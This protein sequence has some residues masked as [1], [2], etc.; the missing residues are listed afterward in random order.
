VVIEEAD[1]EEEEEEEPAAPAEAAPAA[2]E[3]ADVSPPAAAREK[4]EPAV[5]VDE[6]PDT[7][8]RVSFVVRGFSFERFSSAQPAMLEKAVSDEAHAVVAPYIG[9]DANLRIY[10]ADGSAT[11]DDDEAFLD[12]L[13]IV[14]DADINAG[15]SD[16]LIA[17]WERCLRDP[18]SFAG[19]RAFIQVPAA[20]PMVAEGD[21]KAEVYAPDGSTVVAVSALHEPSTRHD[22]AP[23]SQT[24]GPFERDDAS[25]SMPPATP[26]DNVDDAVAGDVSEPPMDDGAAAAAS[27]G[28]VPPPNSTMRFGV[29][30]DDIDG[31]L[32]MDRADRDAA[33]DDNAHRAAVRDLFD[34]CN[35][36][37]FSVVQRRDIGVRLNS[38][39]YSGRETVEADCE[40]DCP[41]AQAGALRRRLEDWLAGPLAF[42]N[43]KLHCAEHLQGVAFVEGVK[44]HLVN[45]D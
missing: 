32:F 42:E 35:V 38:H 8:L 5:V 27:Y 34:A 33:F 7:C 22:P 14:V 12:E 24:A 13:G 37:D 1:E 29:L 40:I 25:G 43:L 4:E 30:L 6:S 17:D 3:A 36:G 18:L 2:S 23:Q 20:E 11:L 10:Y 31:T 28:A 41:P 16:R 26:I 45:W 15:D 21:W 19:L 39:R 9:S 44:A